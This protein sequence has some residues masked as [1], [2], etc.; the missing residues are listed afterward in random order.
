MIAT[1][2]QLFRF[3]LLLMALSILGC[4]GGPEADSASSGASQPK[5]VVTMI[6]PEPDG[7]KKIFFPGQV[8]AAVQTRLS[9]DQPGTIQDILVHKGSRVRS[10]Q[11]LAQ[12]NSSDYR[13]ALNERQARLNEVQARLEEARSSYQR[14][15]ALFETQNVSRQN[16]DQAW[17]TLKSLQAGAKAAQSAVDLARQD[18]KDCALGAPLPGWVADVPMEAHQTVQAGQPVVIVN[19]EQSLEVEISVP[20]GVISK[21]QQGDMAQVRF[22]VLPGE[23]FPARVS[24]I[25]VQAGPLGTYAVVLRLDHADGRI[26]SGM[27]AQA[28]LQTEKK[29][30]YL[31]VPVQAVS[32]DG[33]G[34]RFVWVVNREQGLV[35]RRDVEIGSLS[36][37]GVQIL[38]GLKS[39][40]MIVLRGVHRLREGMEVRVLDDESGRL[41]SEQ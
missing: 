10:G 6:V 26:R 21:V 3:S 28:D 14:I 23:L 9:F 5:P 1:T 37:Q 39:G 32:G 2:Q 16:L 38:S 19:S 33:G 36:D 27:A 29:G 13:L 34:S 20:E 40:E 15:K 8:Q 11:V 12:L 35:N 18:L 30:Q 24:E 41:L 7:P 25:G 22:D 17:G 31:S 4:N